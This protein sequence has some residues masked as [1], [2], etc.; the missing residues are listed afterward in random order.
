MIAFVRHC[1]FSLLLFGLHFSGL[2][3]TISTEALSAHDPVTVEAEGRAKLLIRS[4]KWTAAG[5]PEVTL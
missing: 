3:Q 4:I 2:S 5:W 1:L